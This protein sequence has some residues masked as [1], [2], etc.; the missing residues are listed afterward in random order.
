MPPPPSERPV[1]LGATALRQLRELWRW[2]QVNVRGGGLGQRGRDRRA[3]PQFNWVEL[4]A[5]LAEGGSATFRRLQKDTADGSTYAKTGDELTGYDDFW[6]NLTGSSG[7]R[8]MVEKH[9]NRWVF[10]GVKCS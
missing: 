9:G 8:A 6:Q 5:D 10:M 3:V 4:T 7:D 1:G 2:Y